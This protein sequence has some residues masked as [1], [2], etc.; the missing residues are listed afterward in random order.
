MNPFITQ[1]M[2]RELLE[3]MVHKASQN[4]V[5]KQTSGEEWRQW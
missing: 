5:L 2:L 3:A 1:R 4:S